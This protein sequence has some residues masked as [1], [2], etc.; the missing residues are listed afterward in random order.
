MPRA[1]TTSYHHLLNLKLKV[2]WRK[3]ILKAKKPSHWSCIRI[4]SDCHRCQFNRWTKC[5]L[6]RILLRHQIALSL[7]ISQTSLIIRTTL[8]ISRHQRYNKISW[9]RIL[10]SNM[11]RLW[12]KFNLI[13]LMVSPRTIKAL[14][15]SSKAIRLSP[16]PLSSEYRMETPKVFTSHTLN[17]PKHTSRSP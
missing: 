4:I 10:T 7:L 9:L 17:Q 6:R 8:S 1:S 5:F 12:I 11:C 16:Q 15:F 2:E 3:G 14:R 13:Q